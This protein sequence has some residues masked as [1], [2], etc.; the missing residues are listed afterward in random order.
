MEMHGSVAN[1]LCLK[2]I[3]IPI[4]LNEM[5]YGAQNRIVVFTSLGRASSTY[6][7]TQYK[8]NQNE[9]IILQ[10][11]ATISKLSML[12]PNYRMCMCL[13]NCYNCAKFESVLPIICRDN[14]HFINLIYYSCVDYVRDN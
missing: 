10:F 14:Y 12:Q 3:F 4:L 2:K 13:P 5:Y 1:V 7:I 9:N 11:K 6:I 8:N